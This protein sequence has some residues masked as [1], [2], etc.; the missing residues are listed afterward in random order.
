MLVVALLVI[1]VGLASVLIVNS[2]RQERSDTLIAQYVDKLQGITDADQK[3]AVAQQAAQE[4]KRYAPISFSLNKSKAG[5]ISCFSAL[6]VLTNPSY[7]AY[8]RA[9]AGY[10][11]YTHCW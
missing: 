3:L 8:V 4:I 10:Y 9:A 1:T 6:A 11:Y 5:Y 7:P 2:Y